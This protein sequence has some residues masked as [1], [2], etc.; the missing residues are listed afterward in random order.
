MFLPPVFR[1]CSSAALFLG[2]SASMDCQS[3]LGRGE[4]GPHASTLGLRGSRLHTSSCSLSISS[5]PQLSPSPGVQVSASR[6]P[7]S[8]GNRA[9]TGPPLA[10]VRSP[11]FPAPPNSRPSVPRFPPAQR[12]RTTSRSLGGC[13]AAGPQDSSSAFPKANTPNSGQCLLRQN[14]TPFLMVGPCRAST[15]PACTAL[16]PECLGFSGNTSCATSLAE[17]CL[18]CA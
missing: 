16:T 5:G 18:C 3:P 9:I 17:C 4:A 15:V 6:R 12:G 7:F 10:H 14:K 8:C 1:A 2:H 11:G 13:P